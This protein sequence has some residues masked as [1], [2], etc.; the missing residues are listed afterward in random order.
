[1]IKAIIFDLDGTIY[2][3]NKVIEGATDFIKKLKSNS[4]KYLFIT[5]RSDRILDEIA[6]RIEKNKM[7][8]LGRMGG[9]REIRW[10]ASR[11]SE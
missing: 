6:D 3:G 4:L 5:N 9:S 8:G 7:T 11:M 1:M 10:S 2:H